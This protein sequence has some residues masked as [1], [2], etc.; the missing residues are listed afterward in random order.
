PQSTA[1]V[2]P[3]PVQPVQVPRGLTRRALNDKGVSINN[4]LKLQTPKFSGERNEDPQDFID[5]TEKMVQTLTCSDARIIELVEIKLKRNAWEWFR[6]NIAD[7]LY[8]EN[9]PT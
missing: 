9:S 7:H 8:S 6:R 3:V 5:D 2:P 4:F 1:Q